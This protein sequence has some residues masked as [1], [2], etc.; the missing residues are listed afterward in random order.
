MTSKY[1][2]NTIEV[3]LNAFER[4]TLDDIILLLKNCIGE[5]FNKVTGIHITPM[6]LIIIL[7]WVE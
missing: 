4:K 6:R 3:E 2:T 7:G 1:I 5:N